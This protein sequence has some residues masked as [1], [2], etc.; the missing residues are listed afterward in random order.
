MDHS[1]AVAKNSAN[2]AIRWFDPRQGLQIYD[3]IAEPEIESNSRQLIWAI[4]LTYFEPK[5]SGE[6]G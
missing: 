6:I 3:R 1:S 2:Q 5:L 4:G